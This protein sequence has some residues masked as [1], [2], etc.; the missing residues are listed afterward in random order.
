MGTGSETQQEG[1]WS[2]GVPVAMQRGSAGTTVFG[3]CR[4]GSWT[5]FSSQPM[6]ADNAGS[7]LSEMH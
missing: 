4:E 1:I 3:G 2:R 7:S 5:V 6:S